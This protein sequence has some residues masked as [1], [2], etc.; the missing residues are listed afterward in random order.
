M[1]NILALIGKISSLWES[2]HDDIDKLLERCV[3]I[4]AE[5][6]EVE[7][8]SIYLFNEKNSEIY[9][10]AN[11]GLNK[12][13]AK[14]IRLYP[15]EGLVGNVFQDE[16]VIYEKNAVKNSYYKNIPG[17]GEEDYPLFLG[18]PISFKK[19]KTGVLV[20][21]SSK[22]KNYNNI[23]ISLLKSLAAQLAILI[24]NSELYQNQIHIEDK[25]FTQTSSSENRRI[26]GKGVS[27]GI[28]VG[29]AYIIRDTENL[30]EVKIEK[31][32]S[33]DIDKEEN[34]FEAALKNA[35]SE[36]EAI[37]LRLSENLEDIK[38]II[39]AQ[40]ML[41]KDPGLYK[42]IKNF[43]QK[44]YSL[45][46]ALKLTLEEYKIIFE[47]MSDSYF[48]ERLLDIKDIL[49][50]VLV[51]AQT[52]NEKQ[53]PKDCVIVINEMF[54][55]LFIQLDFTRIKGI[56]TKKMTTT[57]HSV[58][59]ARAQQIPMITG[60]ADVFQFI[61]DNDVIIL[62]SEKEEI[63]INPYQEVLKEYENLIK[64]IEKL[65]KIHIKGKSI[66][67][68]G[69]FVKLSGNIGLMH[70][71]PSVLS[72]H[73]HDVGLYRTEFLFLLRKE[74][75]TEEEQ[76]EIYVSILKK[77]KG[78]EVT[79]RTLDLGGDKQLSYFPLPEE[80]NPLLG[81]RSIRIF[82]KHPQI[83]KEQ[84]KSLLRA[85][86]NGKTR[87]M[88]PLINNN[89]DLGFCFSVLREAEKEL[90]KEKKK[91]KVPAIGIMVETPAAAFN[92]S[93]MASSI[94]FISVGTNDLLQYF[95]AVDRNNIY[96]DDSYS[97]YDPGFIKFLF[98]IGEEAKKNKIELNL[99]GEIAGNPLLTPLLLAAGFQKL[100][101]VPT[102]VEE[103][104]R[105]VQALDMEKI[106]SLAAKIMTRKRSVDVQAELKIF[107]NQLMKK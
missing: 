62:D 21:Q 60:V 49:S 57:S 99:C 94:D 98:F 107:H 12:E 59:M 4:I 44:G 89:E 64:N 7:V 11:K 23:E 66:T 100:S 50:R 8:C 63:I 33:S 90:I 47:N 15:G 35:V 36:L 42:K 38:K 55:S 18:I 69:V 71:I 85:S 43:I 56:V 76:Y 5:H 95:L 73:F 105:K 17:L 10:Q 84:L 86:Y 72:S 58:I 9:L 29:A 103:I 27:K 31:I 41:L 30:D 91:Y 37:H 83:L 106:V 65:S 68:D 46:S 51:F 104:V 92:I 96:N 102:A 53:F 26:K 24:R 25:L 77:L 39:E 101:M 97:F 61:K 40:I 34:Y 88:F 48:Q 81:F 87:I 74:F 19:I 67:K 32:A 75:P 70:E 79:F 16:R 82:K 6:I 3:E 45:A 13:V 22:K 80:E 54:P 28:V 20:L 2:I 93:N 52:K 78:K 1:N 14:T